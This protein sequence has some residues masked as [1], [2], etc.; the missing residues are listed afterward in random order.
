MGLEMVGMLVHAPTLSSMLE[1]PWGELQ[2]HMES[3]SL[4]PQR[5][6][7]DDALTTLFAIDAEAELLDWMDAHPAADTTQATLDVLRLDDE[8][9]EGLLH[10]MRWASPGHWEVWEGRAFLYLEEA[11]QRE[12]EDIHELYTE[13]V[14]VDVLARLHGVAGAEFAERVVLNWMNRRVALG[15]TIEESQD[16]KIVP[17]FEAHQRASKALIH[18]VQRAQN[19]EELVFVLGREHLDAAKWGYGPWNL[20]TYLRD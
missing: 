18:V 8:G 12:V 13:E 7:Q 19:E 15:E 1:L 5:P 9:E 11:I 20:T 2:A 14:W 17:T 4:R 16:P 6:V 3:G 10:L